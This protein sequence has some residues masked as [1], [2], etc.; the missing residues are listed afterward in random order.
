[1]KS[2][3]HANQI[4]TSIFQPYIQRFFETLPEVGEG[5]DIQQ[6]IGKLT[7]DMAIGWMCGED[8][9]GDIDVEEFG[10]A[11]SEAQK[12]VGRRVKIGT[13]WVGALV[14]TGEAC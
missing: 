12:V 7:L 5:F 3:F 8:V 4:D 10:R 6:K 11:M 1:M 2:S 13:V 9:R 14:K